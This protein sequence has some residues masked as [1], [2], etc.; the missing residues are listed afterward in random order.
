M[1]LAFPLALV[2]VLLIRVGA[3]SFIEA[4]RILAPVPIVTAVL[5]GL[6]TTAA[7]ALR[8]RTVAQAFR[9]AAGLTLGRALQECYRSA[10]LNTALPG[11]VAGDAVRVWRRRS[12]QRLHAAAGSVVV[13][14]AAGTFVLFAVAAAAAAQLDR[15][16]ALALMAVA[17][18]AAA[19]TLPG[20]A[21]LSSRARWT[22]AGCSLLA[23][24]AV[25]AQFVVAATVLGTVTDVGDVAVLGIMLL[26]GG[27]VPLGLAGF[28]PRE[29][30]AAF[31]FTAAGLPAASGVTTSAAFGI[32]AMV[33]VLPGALVMLVRSRR[34]IEL[35]ADVLPEVEPSHGSAQRV[36]QPVGSRKPQAGDPVTDQEGCGGDVQPIKDARAEEAG[37]RDTAALHQNPV[38][39]TARQG[40][41]H[42]MW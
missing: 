19:V 14:R 24:A 22:V 4:G 6:V 42:L 25:L 26:A 34:Q 10:F 13:E 17:L 33:S 8:W 27:S 9:A 41:E 29:T 5:L 31:A 7:Q 2:G 36:A 40:V 11:G 38:Q 37:Q 28:G 18:V 30:V 1:R 39:T 32:L 15:R 23:M 16:I 3:D 20:L 12:E 21:R 35:D